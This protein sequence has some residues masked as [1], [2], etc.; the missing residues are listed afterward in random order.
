MLLSRVAESVYWAGR[1]LERVEGTARLVKVH[2]ELFL[3]LPRAAGLG[4]SPLLAATASTD[5]FADRYSVPDEESVVRFLLAD[6]A[7]RG[8]IVASVAQARDNLRSTR[9]VLPTASWEVLSE[10][11]SFVGD[12]SAKAV[13]RRER[14]G[15]LDSVIRQC[16]LLNGLLAGNMSHDATYAFLEIGR[17]LDRADMTTRVLDVQAGILTGHRRSTEPYADVIWMSALQSLGAHQMFRRHAGNPVSGADTLMFLLKNPQFPR[18]VEHCLT[19]ISRNLLELPHC[20]VPMAGC[21]AAQKVIED[22]DVDE[23]VED[24]LS[25]YLDLLEQAIGSVHELVHGTYFQPVPAEPP[26][27]LRSA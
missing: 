16:Q 5:V 23:L 3:D 11:H 1:Y 19:A 25:D 20:E 13:D 26:L 21:A 2:T 7:N 12:T 9:S 4:W 17:A 8:S 18:S 22:A 15:W 10:L 27:L 14:L 24:G 6:D